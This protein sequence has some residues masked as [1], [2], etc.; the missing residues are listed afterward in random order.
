[1]GD[2]FSY[3]AALSY[4]LGTGAAGGDTRD[5][6]FLPRGNRALD[7]ILELN[8]QWRERQTLDG[9]TERNAGAHQLYLSPGLR[10]TAGRHWNLGL[11]FGIPLVEHFNGDQDELDFR[12]VGTVSFYY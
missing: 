8:G 5:W 12:L 3:N 9:R 10:L 7:L 11:S 4:H 2:T 1:M 6:F